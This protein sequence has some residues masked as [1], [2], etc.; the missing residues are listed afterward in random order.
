MAGDTANFWK[1]IELIIDPYPFCTSFQI[2]SMNKNAGSKNPL[3]PNSPFN[4][5]FI[6]II[7]ATAPKGLTSDTTFLNYI[8]IVDA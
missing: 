8:L 2:S 5:F 4:W 1:D 7:P 3:Q 6:D